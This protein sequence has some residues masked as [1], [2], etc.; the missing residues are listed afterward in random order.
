MISSQAVGRAVSGRDRVRRR[1]HPIELA[2]DDEHGNFELA[3]AISEDEVLTV[4]GERARR[5][6]LDR[7]VGAWRVAG[8]V[9]VVDAAF[10]DESPIL[11]KKLQQPPRLVARRLGF[12]PVQQFAVD[13]RP[14]S[15]TIDQRQRADELWT[16]ERKLQCRCATERVADQDGRRKLQL[17]EKLADLARPIP[18]TE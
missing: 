2:P 16:V 6:R 18:G 17:L 12:D 14:E 8:R 11:E 3:E 7:V 9:H 15:G 1:D 13:L 10:E 5:D 4:P